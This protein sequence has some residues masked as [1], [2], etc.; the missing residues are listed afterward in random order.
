M[1]EI[2]KNH[3]IPHARNNYKPHS[4]RREALLTTLVFGVFIVVMTFIGTHSV[5]Q[6]SLLAQVQASLLTELTNDNRSE[7]NAPLL[8]VNPLLEQAA[9]LKARDMVEHEYFAHVSPD[10]TDPWHWFNQVGYQYTFAGENLAS[11]FYETD[12]VLEAWMDSPLHRKNILNPKYTEIGIAVETGRY[13]GRKVAFVVQMFGSPRYPNIQPLAMNS[14]TVPGDTTTASDESLTPQVLGETISLG[15]ETSEQT[16][17]ETE[18]ADNPSTTEGTENQG[19]KPTVV[20]AVDSSQVSSNDVVTEFLAQPGFV[21]K[22]ALLALI[23]LL[24]I[25]IGLKILVEYKKQHY[26]NVMWAVFVLVILI[27]LYFATSSYL[28][29]VVII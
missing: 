14:T 4:V 6:S 9:R 28:S 3:F 15:E 8:T 1:R 20:M 2:F 12:E 17:M 18:F 23:I 13:K 24:S 26:Q 11:D 21:G 5:P 27:I 29:Q 16:Y 10:G 25:S 22:L 7:N 19:D